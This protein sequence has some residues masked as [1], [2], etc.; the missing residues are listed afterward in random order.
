MEKILEM[1]MKVCDKAEVYSYEPKNISVSFE[2]AKLHDIESKFQAGVSLRIIKDGKLGFAYTRNLINRDELLKN[3]LD[4]LEG[5]V[6]AEY[7]FPFT[8]DI[9]QLDTYDSS[10]EK[11]S[12]TEMV[13]ECNRICDLL[14]VETD[15]EIT[16]GSEKEIVEIRIINS[17]G[18]DISAQS[19]GYIIWASLIFPGG[20]S[21]IT[22]IFQNKTFKKI[23]DTIVNDMI[24][25]YK[26]S[27]KVIEPKGGKM[28]VLFMPQSM[29]TLTWRILSGTSSKSIYEKTSPIAN[30][31][32]DEIFSEKITVY[33]DPLNDKYPWAR[34]FDDEGVECKPL[35]I[36]DKGILK[37]FYY[38][39]NYAKKLNA[40]STGHGYRTSM[41]GGDTISIKPHPTL[42][43]LKIQPGN[44][45]FT[46]IVR[47]IDRGLILQ[48]AMGAHSGNIPN[49]DYS[50]GVS[51]GLYVEN[52]EIVGRI[53]DA[54]VAGNIY[55][56]LKHVIDIE[57][58]LHVCW[59][60]M[61]PAI[62]C[63]NVSIATKS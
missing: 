40:Q 24:N 42:D 55:E 44:K 18:T 19:S 6:K 30:K 20:A 23:P 59:S 49:G 2:N 61:M 16:V 34:A 15:G 29:I 21:G 33:D 38:D 52:G 58:T 14:K 5:K 25:L 13:E 51:P 48:G 46:E 31:I 32:G 60:G 53:K 62:L 47:S 28:K 9:A 22:R 7:N 17:A 10:I 36:F 11:I 3:A 43:H 50:V 27:T 57:D 1:A 41:W 63:D 26:S 56:T 45:S 35:T 39:L 12:G 8:K 37:S 4:S 54:M